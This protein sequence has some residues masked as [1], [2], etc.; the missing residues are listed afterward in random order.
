MRE[1]NF[2]SKI[3][4]CNRICRIIDVI[5]FEIYVVV[6]IIIIIIIILILVANVDVSDD[7]WVDV[8]CHSQHILEFNWLSYTSRMKRRRW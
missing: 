3:L 7:F 2:Y 4:S 6:F 5:T 1:I 8:I